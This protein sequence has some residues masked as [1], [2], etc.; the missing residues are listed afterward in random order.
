VGLLG[1]LARRSASAALYGSGRLVSVVVPDSVTPWNLRRT[2]SHTSA[3]LLSLGLKSLNKRKKKKPT[4]KRSTSSGRKPTSSPKRT[5]IFALLGSAFSGRKGQSSN[6][7]H[8]TPVVV[9][10]QATQAAPLAPIRKTAKAGPRASTTKGK[11]DFSRKLR[12]AHL[13]ERAEFERSAYN[14]PGGPKPVIVAE[15]VKHEWTPGFDRNSWARGGGLRS[16]TNWDTPDP[17]TIKAGRARR[18][19]VARAGGKY[20]TRKSR[21]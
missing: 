17:R 5:S 8:S 15:T 11:W 20:K 21:R 16:A 1:S 13:M 10:H 12:P 6:S 18:S 3:S 9:L 14:R 19:R 7:L 2:A 4:K